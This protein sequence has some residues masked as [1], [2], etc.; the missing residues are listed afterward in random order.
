MNPFAL[1]PSLS[2]L[3]GT[4]FGVSV[5]LWGSC[6]GVARGFGRRR[7]ETCMAHSYWFFLSW[8][9]SMFHFGVNALAQ[10][11]PY[12]LWF[13]WLLPGALGAVQLACL[14]PLVRRSWSRGGTPPPVAAA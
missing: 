8:A 14:F 4:L 1:D 11:R 2:W 12:S 7:I 10:G 5:G 9:L 13:G 3:P 6:L